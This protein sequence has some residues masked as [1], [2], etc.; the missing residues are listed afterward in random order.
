MTAG[1][2]LRR[3]TL[4]VTAVLAA[5]AVASPASP[6]L[7]PVPSPALERFDEAVRAQLE[8]HLALLEELRARPDVERATLAQEY[9]KLGRLF[10]AYELLEPA[11]AA[12]ENARRLAPEN[13][14]WLYLLGYAQQQRG[15]L[16]EAAAA[17]RAQ[18]E[19][20]P[21]D[22]AGRLRLAEV[23]L[24][25][26]RVEAA[27][28]LFEA[29]RELPGAAAAARY[30]LGRLAALAGRYDEA[31][32]H[33]EAVLAAQDDA[34]SVR[35]PLALAYRE[36]GRLAEARREL[37]RRGQTPVRF[38]DPRL[39]GLAKLTTGATTHLYRGG[40]ALRLGRRD[41][42]RRHFERAVELDPR[43][44][45]AHRALAF[46][47][48]ES[49]DAAGALEH[50]RRAIALDPGNALLRYNAGT[51]LMQRG[52]LA[53]AVEQLRAA[54]R[55][56]PSFAE[57]WLNLASSLARSGKRQ[58]A[59]AAYERLLELEPE[60]VAAHLIR[61]R[62]LLRLERTQAALDELARIVELAPRTV[63]AYLRRA[64]I[65][66]RLE[67]DREAREVLEAGL[68]AVPESGELSHALA[69]ILA[70][71]PLAEVRD[72]E[73]ALALAR[74]V[75]DARPSVEHLE[76]V[77]MAYAELGQYDRALS[78]QERAIARARRGGGPP[79]TLLEARRDRYRRGEPCRAPWRRQAP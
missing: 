33:F 56:A 55:E 50:F 1:P 70:A 18:L 39:E 8:E 63:P 7:V 16:E 17:L 65:L 3:L 35:Y 20:E 4:L 14:E 31:A 15:A 10:L 2:P 12:L 44:P 5:P 78:W 38:P 22:V 19:R 26:G 62:L 36:L 40:L 45:E 59:L 77:A 41:V 74:Q 21:Q 43:D 30:G 69:R 76:T 48:A 66:L 49:G 23:A 52:D 34:S 58:E 37:A 29:A 25:A 53:A 72:G 11:V 6:E 27:R 57:A 73:R 54:V 68:R 42:A 79:L 9:G 75:A 47:L 13:G 67:R 24:E 60:N 28:A 46:L 32:A 71:S 51:L 64:E 61:A